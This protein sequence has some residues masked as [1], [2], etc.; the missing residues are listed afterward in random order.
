MRQALTKAGV[1]GL[2]WLSVTRTTCVN[3]LGSRSQSLYQTWKGLHVASTREG[4]QSTI[5]APSHLC[6]V[7]SGRLA[8]SQVT[9]AMLCLVTQSCRTLWPRGLQ[10]SRPLRLWGF[11]RQEYWS[12]LSCPPPGQLSQGAKNLAHRFW[13]P[14]SMTYVSQEQGISPSD[15]LLEVMCHSLDLSLK[16]RGG[17]YNWSTWVTE[18]KGRGNRKTKAVTSVM[19]N[20]GLACCISGCSEPILWSWA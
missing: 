7:S 20:E 1:V 10:P 14:P 11:S 19:L 9:F 18:E 17:L 2:L 16:P 13:S 12:G 5:R 4:V 8:S 15:W 3:V 6:L